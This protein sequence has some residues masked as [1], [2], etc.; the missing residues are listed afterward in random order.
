MSNKIFNDNMKRKKDFLFFLC[1]ELEKLVDKPLPPSLKSLIVNKALDKSVDY[2]FLIFNDI[3]N[4]AMIGKNRI[5]SPDSNKI[6]AF[7]N[8]YLM[9][10][11]ERPIPKNRRT[12]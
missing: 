11:N 12:L 9:R 2:E 5:K 1:D 10:T 7:I 3:L 6:G 8:E 4:K